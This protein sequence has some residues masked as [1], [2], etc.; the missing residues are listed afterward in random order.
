[1]VD[2]LPPDLVHRQDVAVAHV[3]VVAL[4]GAMVGAWLGG[5]LVDRLG[6]GVDQDA[7]LN[8]SNSLRSPSANRLG[9]LG[10]AR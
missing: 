8:A 1:M 10:G 4:V 7:G 2:D 9:R 3:E 5:E 6:V